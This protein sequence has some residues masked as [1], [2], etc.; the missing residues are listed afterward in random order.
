MLAMRKVHMRPPQGMNVPDYFKLAWHVQ[1]K[2]DAKMDEQGMFIRFKSGSQPENKT[3]WV[4]IRLMNKSVR[5]EWA[6]QSVSK[7]L[8]STFAYFS[9]V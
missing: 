4:V 2:T 5:S 8:T 9:F 1:S 7:S 3:E 6:I